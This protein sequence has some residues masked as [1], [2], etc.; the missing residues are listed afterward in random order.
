MN[1]FVSRSV[2]L[3]LHHCY[4]RTFH[5]IYLR[6][7]F[8]YTP[9]HF[10][11]FSTSS[12][13]CHLTHPCWIYPSDI[14]PSYSSALNPFYHF[15]YLDCFVSTFFFCPNWSFFSIVRHFVYV[16]FHFQIGRLCLSTQHRVGGRGD[17]FGRVRICIRWLTSCIRLSRIISINVFC[18]S[19]VTLLII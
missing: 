9:K 10:I 12:S 14:Y 19:L 6:E 17:R 18:K 4:T 7:Y 5:T 2:T 8:S 15:C 11:Q 16:L 13:S 1:Y 3:A